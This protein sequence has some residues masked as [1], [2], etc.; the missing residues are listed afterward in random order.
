MHF[1]SYNTVPF[2]EVYSL[3]MMLYFVVQHER[4]DTVKI[5]TIKVAIFYSQFTIKG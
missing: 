4:Y 2:I 5:F 1:E 3:Y